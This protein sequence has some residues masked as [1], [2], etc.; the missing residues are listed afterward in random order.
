MRS[1]WK[2]SGRAPES[3][4]AAGVVMGVQQ[5][6]G[7][8]LLLH[9]GDKLKDAHKYF[10]EELARCWVLHNQVCCCCFLEGQGSNVQTTQAMSIHSNI[11]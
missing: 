9:P 2:Y 11:T 8:D 4:L 3:V 7:S 6:T 5:P 10:T 1:S